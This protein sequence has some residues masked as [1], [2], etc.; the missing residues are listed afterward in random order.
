MIFRKIIFLILLLWII[1]IFGVLVFLLGTNVGTNLIFN[2]FADRIPGLTFDSISGSWG[3]FY[4]T[5]VSYHLP[6]GVINID[7]FRISINLRYILFKQI[8]IEYFF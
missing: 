4:V 1:S 5:N 7:S 2:K 6:L 8:N 3:N